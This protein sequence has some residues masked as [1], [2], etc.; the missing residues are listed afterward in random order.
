MFKIFSRSFFALRG[1]VPLSIRS[2]LYPPSDFPT[3][4]K[5]PQSPL[6]RHRASCRYFLFYLNPEMF[7]VREDWRSQCGVK[8][9]DLQI[10]LQG[11]GTKVEVSESFGEGGVQDEQSFAPRNLLVRDVFAETSY[12]TQSRQLVLFPSYCSPGIITAIAHV[13]R[14]RKTG[15]IG[16]IATV[17]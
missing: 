11:E 3:F 4:A 2:A 10:L 13:R 17:K 12:E 6:C 8:G 14:R 16:I 1:K 9:R 5:I 15:S 7:L